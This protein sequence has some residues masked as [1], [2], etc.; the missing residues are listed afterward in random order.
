MYLW[1]SFINVCI[2]EYDVIQTTQG[3]PKEGGDTVKRSDPLY[4]PVEPIT[5]Q[6]AKKIKEAITGL[7]QHMM[8]ECTKQT[9]GADMQHMDFIEKGSRLIHV[10]QILEDQAQL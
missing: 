2:Y 7:T 9:G 1:I 5:K 10:I 6:R 4:V 3:E 8:T